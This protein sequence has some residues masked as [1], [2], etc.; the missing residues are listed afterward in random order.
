M[1]F[2]FPSI[3]CKSFVLFTSTEQ[4]SFGSKQNYARRN[5]P[6]KDFFA[7]AI[8]V[9]VPYQTVIRTIRVSFLYLRSPCLKSDCKII[10][11]E[12]C[13][14]I[15]IGCLWLTAILLLFFHI[16]ASVLVLVVIPIVND[17]FLS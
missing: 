6:F 4:P 3:F 12:C 1:S 17:I 14:F 13:H 10:A 2:Q 16:F 11:Q 15:Y 9:S 7:I 5:V 8:R